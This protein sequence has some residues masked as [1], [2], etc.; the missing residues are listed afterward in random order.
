M[1]AWRGPLDPSP[2]DRR[3]AAL[4]RRWRRLRDGIP[5]ALYLLAWAVAL[6]AVGVLVGVLLA[7]VVS[8]D[9]VGRADAGVDRWLAAHR[10]GSW[11]S[12][13]RFTTDAAETPTIAA[14]AALTF[15]GAVLAWRRWREPVLV[16]AAV[17]GEVLV[18]LAITLLVKR[19]R[20]PVGHL[21]A[22]PPTSSFPSGH[23]AAAI[24]LYGAWAVL[25]WQHAR[26]SLLRGLLTLLAVAVPVAVGAA[27]MYRGMHYPSDVIGGALLGAIWLALSVRAVRLGVLHRRL[28]AGAGRAGRRQPLLRHG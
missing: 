18:F 19:P 26:S 2:S 16:A 7:K 1:D 6:V 11:N 25:A 27:R 3:E 22:A 9:A 15:A 13:T 12:V 10:T 24:A 5:S 21:D 23:T 20:P 14:L 17:L 4:A 8:H 28:R